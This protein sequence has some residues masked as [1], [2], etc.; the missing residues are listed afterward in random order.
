MKRLWVLLMVILV[1]AAFSTCGTRENLPPPDYIALMIDSAVKGDME[2]GR[3]AEALQ[4]NDENYINFDDFYLLSKFITADADS[5]IRRDEYL[6]CVGEI[7]LNR[8]ASPEFPHSI[9][10]VIYDAGQYPFANTQSFKELLPDR[11]CCNAAM[12]LLQGE[13]LM[14]NTVVFKSDFKVGPVYSSYCDRVAGFT[15]FCESPNREL[16]CTQESPCLSSSIIYSTSSPC[17]SMSEESF[18]DYKDNSI[19]VVAESRP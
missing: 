17:I 11:A 3:K 6:M 14:K 19:I 16:Y 7:I 1:A 12:H 15:Y 2:E 13:R 4:A 8:A 5:R 18:R 9:E 10:A